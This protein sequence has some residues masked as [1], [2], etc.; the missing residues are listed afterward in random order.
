MVAK[1]VRVEPDYRNE[2]HSDVG[3]L[4]KGEPVTSEG[5]LST[6]MTGIKVWDLQVFFLN[7]HWLSGP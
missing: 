2:G 1:C 4:E 5:S 3:V 7:T 6:G